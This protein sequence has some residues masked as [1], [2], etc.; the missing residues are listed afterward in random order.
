MA[1]ETHDYDKPPRT[2]SPSDQLWGRGPTRRVEPDDRSLDFGDTTRELGLT[3]GGI[4]AVFV[5]IIF[6][7][8]HL[9]Q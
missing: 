7:V 9:T 1:S 3:L 5:V 4:C 2:P 6:I 8:E